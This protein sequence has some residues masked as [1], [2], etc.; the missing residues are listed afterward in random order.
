MCNRQ[1]LFRTAF[2]HMCMYM[3]M[4]KL[5]MV[6]F[7]VERRFFVQLSRPT[8]GQSWSSSTTSTKSMTTLCSQ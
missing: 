1:F 2:I 5:V 7:C 8:C 4:N 3:V 6:N